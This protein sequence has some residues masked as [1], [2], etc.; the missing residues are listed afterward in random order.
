MAT[1]SHRVCANLPVR[2]VVTIDARKILVNNKI[3][4]FTA[5]GVSCQCVSV[6]E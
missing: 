3:P 6:G 5:R 1:P 2:F 4:L